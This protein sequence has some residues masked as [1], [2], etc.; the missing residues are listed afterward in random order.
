MRDA[1]KEWESKGEQLKKKGQKQKIDSGVIKELS[2]KISSNPNLPEPKGEHPHMK[3]EIES[4]D[5]IKSNYLKEVN[6]QEELKM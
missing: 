2:M 3:K 4:M 5:N 1:K 6:I